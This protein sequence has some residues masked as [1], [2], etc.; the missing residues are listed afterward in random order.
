MTMKPNPSDRAEQVAVYQLQQVASSSRHDP[1]GGPLW[2]FLLCV[3]FSGI[4]PEIG[5]VEFEI[6]A[7]WFSSMALWA[8]VQFLTLRKVK[9][10]G[11]DVLGA[12]KSGW[13]VF[14]LY[15]ANGAVWTA[16]VWFFWHPGNQLNHILLSAI[17]L[18]LSI[19]IMGM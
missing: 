5:H 4:A 12:E 9:Q 11:I 19:V 6:I 3:M 17:I 15:A 1:I 7:A 13:I 8:I 10:I 16:F 14:A 18:A 2:V